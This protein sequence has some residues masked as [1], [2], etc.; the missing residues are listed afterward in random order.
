M[1]SYHPFS[2][3]GLVQVLEVMKYNDCDKLTV[4]NDCLS[5]GHS[6]LYFVFMWCNEKMVMLL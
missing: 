4:E 2:D 1:V 3:M 6:S 5:Y